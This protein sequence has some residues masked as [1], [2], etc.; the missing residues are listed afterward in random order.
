MEV[1]RHLSK[2]QKELLEQFAETMGETQTPKSKTFFDKVK[3]VFG[4]EPARERM[5]VPDEPTG[6]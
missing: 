4:G 5:D 3:E 6:S 1:P 2:K